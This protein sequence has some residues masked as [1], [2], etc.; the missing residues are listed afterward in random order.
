VID[1][2]VHFVGNRSPSRFGTILIDG[3]PVNLTGSTVKNQMR[4]VGSSTLKVDAAAVLVDAANGEVRYDW[5]ATDVDTAGMYAQWWRVTTGAGLIQDTP[6]SLLEIRAHAAEG[7]EYVSVAELKETLALQDTTF[8]DADLADAVLT[9]SR[10]V[11]QRCGRQFYLGSPGE[12]RRY[13]AISEDYVL[14]DDATA[15]NSVTVDGTTAVLNTDYVQH[16]SPVTVLRALNGYRFNRYTV[17]GVVVT[18]QFGWAP[19]P[20]QVKEATKILAARYLKRTREATFAV[21]G[22]VDAG[23]RIPGTDPDV[24]RLLSP[25]VRSGMIE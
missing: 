20:P 4:E 3:V 14:I 16:G 18:G 7:N 6:E 24:D 19:P 10:D 5:L 22:F 12:V 13:T 1:H 23:V 8:A 2:I 9:A 21:I 17:N 15:I 25:Y 11:D